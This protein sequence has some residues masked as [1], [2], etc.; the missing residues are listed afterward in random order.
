MIICVRPSLINSTTVTRRLPI[1]T[2][3]QLLGPMDNRRQGLQTSTD[4][5][6]NHKGMEVLHRPGPRGDTGVVGRHLSREDILELDMAL[7]GSLTHPA[8][9]GSLHLARADGVATRQDIELDRLLEYL[10]AGR[11]IA[12]GGERHG[13]AGCRRIP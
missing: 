9:M 7:V 11:S 6:H 5:L 3:P 2:E 1:N 10:D 13:P 4:I 12:A 8:L